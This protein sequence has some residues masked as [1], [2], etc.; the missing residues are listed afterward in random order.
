M[1]TALERMIIKELMTPLK[2]FKFAPR[3]ASKTND[4]KF[5]YT[6]L[7]SIKQ[8]LLKEMEKRFGHF[9]RNVYIAIATL[10]DPKFKSC[11]YLMQ[12]RVLV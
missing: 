11:M 8:L 6:E 10:L 7:E 3:E 12:Q 2:P 1:L 9:N 5:D 4:G